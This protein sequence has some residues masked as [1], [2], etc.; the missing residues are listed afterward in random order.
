MRKVEALTLPPEKQ[1]DNQK[2]RD[3][4]EVVS[5]IFQKAGEEKSGVINDMCDRIQLQWAVTG[6]GVYLGAVSKVT[7]RCGS[8]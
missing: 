6:T 4:S 1:Q 5:S 3:P 8:Q 2:A 7:C